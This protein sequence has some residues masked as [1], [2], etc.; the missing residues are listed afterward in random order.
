MC[1]LPPPPGP[2]DLVLTLASAA[3]PDI[4]LPRVWT[5]EGLRLVLQG[6][7]AM[8]GT[9]AALQAL[10][11]TLHRPDGLR[12]VAPAALIKHAATG[13]AWLNWVLDRPGRWRI[14]ARCAEPRPALAWLIVDAV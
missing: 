9:P 2:P 13:Q 8:T 6:R 12:I 11:I 3:H 14:E 5:G 10:R 7:N 1:A 4:V